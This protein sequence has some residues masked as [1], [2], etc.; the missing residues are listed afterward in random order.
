MLKQI[1][2][3]GKK[4]YIFIYEH[5]V[6]KNSQKALVLQCC[7]V[8]LKVFLRVRKFLFEFFVIKK[9]K[10]GFV[11]I[12]NLTVAIATRILARQ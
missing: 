12:R 6:K 3:S 9:K 5:T 4:R 10:N 8:S 7:A 11:L 1:R 2:Q